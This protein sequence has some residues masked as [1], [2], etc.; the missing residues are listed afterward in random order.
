MSLQGDYAVMPV[1]SGPESM[2][3]QKFTV[4][5][6]S[7]YAVIVSTADSFAALLHSTLSTCTTIVPNLYIHLQRS[8]FSET[9][10][11]MPISGYQ[12]SRICTPQL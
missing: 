9:F 7:R 11:V 5:Q 8:T 1:Y 6:G 10:F 2:Y 3:V 4:I 12:Q